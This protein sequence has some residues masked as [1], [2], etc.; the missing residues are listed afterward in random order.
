[1]PLTM[2]V[3]SLLFLSAQ[4]P[5]NNHAISQSCLTYKVWVLLNLQLRP[6]TFLGMS[7]HPEDG[8]QGDQHSALRLEVKVVP[9]PIHNLED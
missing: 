6:C 1:M 5:P 3:F 4:L 9:G 8:N 2:N 7:Q